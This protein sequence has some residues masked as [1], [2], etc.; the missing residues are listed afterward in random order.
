MNG[1]VT[2]R[3]QTEAAFKPALRQLEAVDDRRTH[4]RRIG[5]TSRDQQFALIDDAVDLVEVTPGRAT[6]TST[7]RSVSR[8][9]TGGSQAT[10]ERES[11]GGRIADAC[12]RRARA[13]RTPPTTSSNSEILLPSP[14]PN[15]QRRH[16]DPDLPMLNSAIP[17]RVH[18]MALS[19]VVRM[20]DGL[21]RRG[22]S[23]NRDRG[24][25]V[26]N[27]AKPSGSG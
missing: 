7:A 5:P 11:A 10:G 12:A 6:S 2:A 23:P 1:A 25:V 19:A 24:R 14:H 22:T 27:S 9:S 3:W 16:F 8:M 21:L 20:E 4:L 18:P 15:P 26:S 13:F 17:V